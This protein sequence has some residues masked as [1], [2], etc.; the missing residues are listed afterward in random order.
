MQLGEIY[1]AGRA[2][3]SQQRGIF[4]SV[5]KAYRMP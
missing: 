1:I 4:A 3:Y 2:L 5:F